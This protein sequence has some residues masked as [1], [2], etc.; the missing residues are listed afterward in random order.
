MKQISLALVGAIIGICIA[1][2]PLSAQ[3][4]DNEE[5]LAKV[6][7]LIKSDSPQTTNEINALLKGKNKKNVELLVAIGRTYLEAGKVKEAQ[8]YVVLAKK[9]N[10]KSADA[11]MLEGDI[12]EKNKDIGAA[13]QLYEQAIYFDPKC[14]DAY[15]KYANVYRGANP[16]LAV[17]K[18]EQLKEIDPSFMGAD[19]AIANVYYSNNMFDKASEV[20]A[21][22][23]NTPTA[24]EEDIVK[25]A[26]ALFL[27]HNFEKSLEVA[28]K[29]LERNPRNA[30]FNRL[31]MYNYAD[32]K[33]EKEGL[34]AAERFFKQSE[35][36]DFAY[37]DYLY[38]AHLLNSNKQY[39]AAIAQ[40]EKAMEADKTKGN[41]WHEI[42]EAY[43]KKGDHKQAITYYKK[44]YDA[45]P[46]E[47]QTID[48]RLELGKL[49]YSMGNAQESTYSSAEKEAAL[50]EA[51]SIFA[52]IANEAPQSYLGNLWRART[53]S[54]LDPETTQGLAKP[55]YEAVATLLINK[56]ES[57]FNSA[58]IECY[59]YLGY[60]Y[61]ISNQM[62]ESKEYWNKILTI[63]PENEVAKRALEGIK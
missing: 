28:Q 42:S 58:L 54:A 50:K 35:K 31:V 6:K 57:R 3:S 41:L 26:F 63:N 32:M 21:R 14:K 24:T 40:F 30:A 38:Y 59:S 13:C 10:S 55:Y 12:A 33:K 4:V 9:A 17:E 45:L 2:T 56:N 44:Y 15:L 49:Y 52:T 46:E 27:N 43:E 29:G 25:Y 34:E 8:D 5:G 19:K 20:Y 22:F 37:L 16:Q 39:D 18:L 36:P 7:E 11:Y 23:I 47:K 51:D 53:N 1:S 61:L 62:E 48:L 60:Y